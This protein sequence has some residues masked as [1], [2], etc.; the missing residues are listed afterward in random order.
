MKIPAAAFRVEAVGDG[1]RFQQG[2]LFRS[3]LADEIRQPWD[4]V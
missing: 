3:V 1:D 4:A 2:R